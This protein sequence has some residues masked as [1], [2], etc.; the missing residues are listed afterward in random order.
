[1]SGLRRVSAV[2]TVAAVSAFWFTIYR[3]LPAYPPSQGLPLAV[4]AL[5]F[6]FVLVLL[7]RMHPSTW[8]GIAQ[9]G[10][11]VSAL[12]LATWIVGGTLRAL[13]VQIA[14]PDSTWQR[15][16]LWLIARPQPGWGLFSVGLI[17]IGFTAIT[18][19]LSVPMRL[20][21]PLGAHFLLGEPLKYALGDRAGGVTILVLFGLGWLAIAALLLFENERGTQR[22]SFATEQQRNRETE[23]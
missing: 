7:H 13:D 11:I 9:F 2:T 15:F 12:G 21:L 20:L 1:M 6:L 8:P 19:R 10:F 14:D 16:A 18:N 23:I 22:N 17:P 3:S 5:L 4:A